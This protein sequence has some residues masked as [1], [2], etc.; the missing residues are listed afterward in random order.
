MNKSEGIA[1]QQSF[2]ESGRHGIYSQPET[3][4]FKI[5]RATSCIIIEQKRRSWTWMW[6]AI[7]EKSFHPMNM[8][9]KLKQDHLSKSW[10][11]EQIQNCYLNA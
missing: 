9:C 8:I 5:G 11:L 10:G 2:L 4:I 6:V 1:K 7:K 3:Q